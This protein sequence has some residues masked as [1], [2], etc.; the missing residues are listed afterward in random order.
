MQHNTSTRA[1]RFHIVLISPERCETPLITLHT[2]WCRKAV[3]PLNTF[4]KASCQKAASTLSMLHRAWSRNRPKL[5]LGSTR[6]VKLR[7]YCRYG[8]VFPRRSRFAL[9]KLCF[10]DRHA[11]VGAVA[12][13]HHATTLHCYM[14]FTPQT[15]DNTPCSDLR[16]RTVGMALPCPN[17]SPISELLGLLAMIKCGI[18]SCELICLQ[19]ETCSSRQFLLGKCLPELAWGPSCVGLISHWASGI[20]LLLLLLGGA[21]LLKL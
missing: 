21:P 8:P 12:N 7:S 17:P 14:P 11:V 20:I 19:L 1:E 4:H 9:E 6:N 5:S 3:Q 13:C 15:L 10:S 2:V 16:V 18:Y